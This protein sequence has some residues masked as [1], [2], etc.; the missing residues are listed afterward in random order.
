MSEEVILEKLNGLGCLMK[1]KFNENEKQ[2]TTVIAQVTKTNGRVRLLEK[3][4]WALGGGVTILGIVSSG[5]IFP[6]LVKSLV[7]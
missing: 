1:E 5:V 4:I 2:H 7:K 3:F 6:I